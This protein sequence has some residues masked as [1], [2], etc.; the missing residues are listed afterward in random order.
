MVYQLYTIVTQFPYLMCAY[1]S[2]IKFLR[3][4]FN[5]LNVYR[6]WYEFSGHCVEFN[7]HGG[8][9]QDQMTSPCNTI[10]PKCDAIFDSTDA[11]KCNTFNSLYNLNQRSECKPNSYPMIWNKDKQYIKFAYIENIAYF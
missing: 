2:F 8:V 10:F 9:I 4:F 7:L 5:L 3:V 1:F 6:I 11:Y